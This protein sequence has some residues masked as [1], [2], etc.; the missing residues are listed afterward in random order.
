MSF[1][2]HMD[3]LTIIEIIG[4]VLAIIGFFNLS[5][6]LEKGFGAMQRGFWAY[7]KFQLEHRNKY[8][9]PHKNIKA[10]FIG[11][12]ESFPAVILII[13]AVSFWLGWWEPLRVIIG[14][15]DLW[16]KISLAIGLFPF[17]ILNELFATFVL[18]SIV[19]GV[20]YVLNRFFW[21]LGKPP[22][23]VTGTLGL[24]LTITSFVMGRAE[25][26]NALIVA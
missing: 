22:S 14:G 17:W 20:F 15:L 1:T 3:I 21:L 4:I 19:A 16:V 7:A 8:W 11:A 9:P 18:T 23:G 26:A 5:P 13:T 2:F 25:V 12:A 10:M 6:Q 24:M